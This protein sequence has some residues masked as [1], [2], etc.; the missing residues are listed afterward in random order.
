MIINIIGHCVVPYKRGLTFYTCP[1]D[2][3]MYSELSAFYQFP[4]ATLLKGHG[5]RT[6]R[7]ILTLAQPQKQCDLRYII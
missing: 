2:E 3:A 5:H 1:C 4:S 7:L 6:E